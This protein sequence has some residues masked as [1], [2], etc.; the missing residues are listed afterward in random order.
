[1]KRVLHVLSQRPSLTGSG[2]TLD[3]VVRHAA[4]AGSEQRVVCGV[5]ASD[6]MLDAT[7]TAHA[8]WFIVDATDQRRA[9]LNCISHLL[10]TI[11]YRE[12]TFEAPEMPD[13]DPAKAYDDA[14]ALESRRFVPPVY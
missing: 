13:R 14:G 4:A 12:V 1:M 5:P 7:D 10:S 9:R 6:A 2:V 8:P 11:P 3:G